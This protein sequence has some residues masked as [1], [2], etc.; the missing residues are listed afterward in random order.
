MVTLAISNSFP[1][2]K[3]PFSIFAQFNHPFWIDIEV[4]SF[5]PLERTDDFLCLS[6][7]N[8]IAGSASP[9][10]ERVLRRDTD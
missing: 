5:A 4:L 2:C 6:F 8:S 3:S 10:N 1:V 9:W 7:T